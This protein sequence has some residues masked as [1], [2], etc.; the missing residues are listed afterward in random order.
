MSEM[1]RTCH[2]CHF[3]VEN[4]KPVYTGKVALDRVFTE[5]DDYLEHRRIVHGEE[6][7]E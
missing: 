2:Q 4:G 1:P 3:R 6:P 5:F 7:E